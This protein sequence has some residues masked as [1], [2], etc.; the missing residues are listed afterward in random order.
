MDESIKQMLLDAVEALQCEPLNPM[1]EEEAEELI[2]FPY[3]D[4][5]RTPTRASD[6]KR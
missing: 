3:Q 5:Q 2:Y 1:T 6:R 4:P